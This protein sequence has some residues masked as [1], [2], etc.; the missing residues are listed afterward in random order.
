MDTAGRIT[1]S[2]P[3]NPSYITKIKSIK[4]H[5]WHPEEKYWRVPYSELENLLSV[6]DGEKA[7]I[8]SALY[9]EPLRKE[10]A[11]RKYSRRTMKMYLQYNEDFLRFARKTPYKISNSDVRDY[12]YHLAEE[13]DASASTLNIAINALKFYYG[14]ILKRGFAYGIKRPKKD[15]KMPVVLSPEEVSKIL[16]SLSNIKHKAILMLMYS[17]GLRVGEVVK[18]RVEDIDTG[19]KLIHIRG[20]KGRKDRYT[21]LSDVA[22]ET[23]KVYINACNPENW[24]FPGG[25]G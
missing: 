3:Y 16:S 23:L 10:L 2:F 19:R 21:I 6:F 5:R 18:L 4:G 14:E 1:V 22:L 15:K 11:S 25:K 7:D 24:L 8:D 12:L 13:R 9:F 20:G 17:A